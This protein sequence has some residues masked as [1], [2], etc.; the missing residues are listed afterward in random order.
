MRGCALASVYVDQAPLILLTAVSLAAGVLMLL[1]FRY[2]S[3]QEKIRRAKDQVQAQLLA[4]RLFQDQ[5][6]AV[7]LAYGRLV[8]GTVRYIGVMLKP[9]LILALIFAPVIVLLDPY[10]GWEP[11]R[12][13][14][15]FL[16][17][18][19]VAE[20]NVL[21][22]VSLELP[23]GIV[24]SAPPVHIA[25][26]QQVVWRLV[27]DSDGVYPV[28]VV[29]NGATLSKP[30]IVSAGLPHISATSMRGQFWQ[31][32]LEPGATALPD[33][34]P[35]RSIAVGYAPREMNV[36]LF[37]TNWIIL[38]FVISIVAALLFKKAL[39]VEI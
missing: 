39:H 21:D 18:V 32:W 20:P 12:P 9:T 6:S 7:M 30:V 33:D 25:S 2:T 10:F 5:L 3:D 28:T 14:Q 1:V 35:V 38:F 34:S 17:K 4:V 26:D 36:W 11:L 27:A 24:S 15:P 19:G 23:A 37:Q 8:R 22:G 13:Q 31:R 29:A 16:M